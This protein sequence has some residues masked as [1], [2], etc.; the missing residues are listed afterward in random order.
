M[1]KAIVF[2][3][4]ILLTT[5]SFGQSGISDCPDSL[6]WRLTHDTG[7]RTKSIEDWQNCIK[8]KRMPDLF[9]QTISGKKIETKKLLGKVLVIN[10]WFTGC[11]P[12]VAE[13]PAL[14]QLVKEYNDK[15]VVFLAIAADAKE[16]LD[17]QF[18]PLH[19]FDFTI[20]ADGDDVISRIGKTGFPTTYI[21]DKKGKI[22]DAWIGGET[23][24]RAKTAAYQRAKPI[25]DGLLTAQ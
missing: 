13:I 16:K 21:I 20:I 3:L 23:G 14:N 1:K 25:I 19:K 22:R 9:L 11:A 17:S 6:Y 15:D 5:I 8:G 18:L 10:L 7:M 2:I 4:T 24:E 12:C